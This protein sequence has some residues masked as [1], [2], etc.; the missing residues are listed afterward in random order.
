MR[1]LPRR[2]VT[3]Y[4]VHWI[5]FAEYLAL[6]CDNRFQFSPRTA[7]YPYLFR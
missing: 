3:L 6:L 2:Q 5:D 4:E 1:G 7:T